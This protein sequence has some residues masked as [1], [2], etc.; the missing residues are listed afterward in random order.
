M[1]QIVR[2]LTDEEATTAVEYAVLLGLIVMTA[3]GAIS[4]FGQGA[5]GLF[6]GIHGSLQ[7]V[8]FGN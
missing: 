6:S 2:F 1:K 5:G 4:T 8:G 7:A 3:I